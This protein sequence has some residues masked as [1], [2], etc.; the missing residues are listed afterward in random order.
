MFLCKIFV[1]TDHSSHFWNLEYIPA[2]IKSVQS[3]KKTNYMSLFV[4]Y[5]LVSMKKQIKILFKILFSNP[6][7]KHNL[8]PMF[9]P[10]F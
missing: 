1:K 7:A 5:T 2:C 3:F 6:G 9:I 4:V 10:N 8:Q